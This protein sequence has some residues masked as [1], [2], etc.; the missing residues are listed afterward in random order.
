MEEGQLVQVRELYSVSASTLH[1]D[2]K[3]ISISGDANESLGFNAIPENCKD[4]A[5][6]NASC[7]TRRTSMIFETSFVCAPHF[8]HLGTSSSVSGKGHVPPHAFGHH[9]RSLQS[10]KSV[11]I[12]P[13]FV[14]DECTQSSQSQTKL[15][16]SFNSLCLCERGNV[17]SM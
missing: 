15:Y 7:P 1:L 10:T 2:L 17:T 9:I 16:V 14:G 4:V 13:L 8:T 12:S 5:L 6:S 11:S 3:I